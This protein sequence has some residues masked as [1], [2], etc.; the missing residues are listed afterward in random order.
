MH[1]DEQKI[2]ELI[3]AWLRATSGSNLP[4]LFKLMD[5]EAVFL[6]PG[7]PPM[8]GRDAFAAAFQAALH[9]FGIEATSEIQEVRTAGDL[10]YCWSHLRVTMT[11]LEGG[12]PMRRKRYT[13]TV[14]AKNRD[15]A[16]VLARG[17][18]LLAPDSPSPA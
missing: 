13:L 5:E 8:R 18:N 1:D 16:W 10:A 9:H 14:F 2:R 17:A 12:S 7:Q 15:G 11:P 6:T 4:E 3:A